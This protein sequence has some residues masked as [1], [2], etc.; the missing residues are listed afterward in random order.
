MCSINHELKAIFI[1]LPKCGG[2]TVQNILEQY[3]GFNTVFF[4]H[5]NHEQ[6]VDIRDNSELLLDVG[7]SKVEKC[8]Q[9][10]KMGFLRYYMSSEIHAEKANVTQEQ[11]NS[12][13][14]F[15]FIRNPYDRFVSAWKY[16]LRIKKCKDSKKKTEQIETKQIETEQIETEQI[17]NSPIS[18]NKF[19]GLKYQ[20]D[21]YSFFHAFI[22]Q[23][24]HLLNTNNVLDIDFFGKFENLNR[25]LVDVLITLGITNIVHEKFILNDYKVNNNSNNQ[26]Y[27][28]YYND[29]NITII[30]N[31]LESDFKYL[32]FTKYNTLTEMVNDSNKYIK[33]PEDFRDNNSKLVCDLLIKGYCNNKSDSNNTGDK[34][35]RK[36][37]LAKFFQ[38]YAENQAK[39]ENKQLL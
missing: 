10:N 20:C 31:L 16:L 15:T 18:L 17:D 1:H 7:Q 23:Y 8:L 9:F 19:I 30:N 32:G 35:E 14:K 28:S 33:T 12:Y 11:W 25:D 22:T 37:N 6:F 21:E 4:S 3:Y 27:Y 29:E 24:D 5:E 34:K 39:N 2:L 26:S 13:Y 38:L 36:I